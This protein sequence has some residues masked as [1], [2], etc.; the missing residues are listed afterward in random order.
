MKPRNDLTVE[1][2]RSILDYNQETGVFTWKCRTIDTNKRWE[3]KIAGSK[4]SN[5][6]WRILI[7]YK[8]Y[9]AHRL[10]WLYMTGGWPTAEVD[11]ISGIKSENRWSNLRAATRIENGCNRRVG[12]NNTSGFKGVH[13]H[14][15]E[16]KWRAVIYHHKKQIELGHFDTPEE[17]AYFYSYASE[18]YHGEFR[19]QA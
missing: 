5:G 17:A 1:Y 3:G 12:L 6:Y 15:S 11:H 2:V 16:K 18:Y 14:K 7:D 19:R 10:A 8:Q 9:L 13:F 4:A